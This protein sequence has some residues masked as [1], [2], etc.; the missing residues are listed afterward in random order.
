MLLLAYLT[1]LK[2]NIDNIIN[3]CIL[4]FFGRIQLAQ[5]LNILIGRYGVTAPKR[6]E[7]TMQAGGFCSI[8]KCEW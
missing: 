1:H 6:L 5:T 3:V 7:T 4:G 8:P 2:A